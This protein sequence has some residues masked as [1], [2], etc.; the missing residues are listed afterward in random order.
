M[1]RALRA[2]AHAASG[3]RPPERGCQSPA[4]AARRRGHPGEAR[5]AGHGR[6]ARRAR[7]SSRNPTSSGERSREGG[8][9]PAGLTEI[10]T[11]PIS[12]CND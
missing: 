2:G 12:R 8:E 1:V 7:G 3:H 10:G 11:L 6:H 5:I 9:D 4:Q